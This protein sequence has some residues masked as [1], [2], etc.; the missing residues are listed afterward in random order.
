MLNGAISPQIA[1]MALPAA[2]PVQP[3]FL[4]DKGIRSEIEPK[5]KEQDEQYENILEHKDKSDTAS[6]LLPQI[7]R[8]IRW[9]LPNLYQQNAHRLLKKIT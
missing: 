8:I 5:E 1:R 2:Q 9:N 6:A 3:T 4:A 7:K